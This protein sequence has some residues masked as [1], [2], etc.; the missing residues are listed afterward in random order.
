MSG[1]FPGRGMLKLRFE[2]YI[3]ST[4]AENTPESEESKKPG[5]ILPLHTALQSPQ[6]SFPG[7]S[8]V[9]VTVEKSYIEA[10]TMN[11]IT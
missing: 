5:R 3:S 6:F 8:H 1:E 10:S 7:P 9:C 4:T 11:E 2:W